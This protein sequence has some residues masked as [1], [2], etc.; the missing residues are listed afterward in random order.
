MNKIHL[1]IYL[2]NTCMV[3]VASKC[4]LLGFC[5]LPTIQSMSQECNYELL[6]NYVATTKDCSAL[7]TITFAATQ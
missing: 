7:G 1:F 6:H 3:T 5:R 4:A 2:F